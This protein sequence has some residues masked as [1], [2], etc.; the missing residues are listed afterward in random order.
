VTAITQG[1]DFAIDV[2]RDCLL[3]GPMRGTSGASYAPRCETRYRCGLNQVK[4][5]Q[6]LMSPHDPIGATD[7]GILAGLAQQLQG[8]GGRYGLEAMCMGGAR[9]SR[10]FSSE[11]DSRIHP[12]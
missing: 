10:P 2:G 7:V 11:F 9:G 3:I 6:R 8:S 4:G 1:V 5:G 12:A